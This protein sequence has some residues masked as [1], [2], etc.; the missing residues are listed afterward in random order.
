MSYV[1]SLRELVRLVQHHVTDTD[2][3]A[4]T[5]YSK[6]GEPE[7]GMP[8]YFLQFSKD[9]NLDKNQ[10]LILAAALVAYTHPPFLYPLAVHSVQHPNDFIGAYNDAESGVTYPGVQTL[11]YILYGGNYNAAM[12]KCHELLD[13]ELFKSGT[14]SLC[15]NEKATVKNN[16]LQK[17]VYVSDDY[18]SYFLTGKYGSPKFSSSFPAQKITTKLTWNDLVLDGPTLAQI[19][20]ITSWH[21]H[22]D[23]VLNQWNLHKMLSPGYKVLFHGAPGTGK[24]LTAAIMGQELGIDVFRIDLSMV[25]SKYIGETEKNLSTLFDRAMNK[26]WILFF[27]E[28]DALF[29]SRTEVKDS[30]DRYANQEVSYLLQRVENYNGIIILASNLKGNMDR[31]FSR[32]FQG[33]IKFKMPDAE[34]RKRLWANSFSPATVLE[35][36]FSLHDLAKT[37]ELAGGS[38]INVVQYASLKAA[39]R[40]NNIILF[41]DVKSGVIRELGKEGKTP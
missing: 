41:S 20:E 23:V 5:L 40:G 33:M 6:I 22:R 19:Q 21:K 29:G 35:N 10:Q 17:I 37:Y 25:V 12:H 8:D 32:R 24:T 2:F 36:N 27:D 1:E 18:L 15:A 38:I 14:L 34:Q 11:L 26:N 30:H 7:T 3:D 16:R 13:N 9:K 39:E 4:E 28:A 31:A